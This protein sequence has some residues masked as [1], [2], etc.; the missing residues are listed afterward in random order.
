LVASTISILEVLF[1]IFSPE[2]VSVSLCIFTISTSIDGCR[3]DA[4]G[5]FLIAAASLGKLLTIGK[6]FVAHLP[7]A[8][9]CALLS[10]AVSDACLDC[11]KV[12][13]CVADELL[14][15]LDP[16][17]CKAIILME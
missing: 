16:D 14:H 11:L 13:V 10:S 6:E 12:S 17:G 15:E 3:Q 2:L 9:T 4:L 8:F 7:H 5:Q 1:C